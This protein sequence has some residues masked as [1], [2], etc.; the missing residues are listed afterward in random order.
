MPDLA[1][2][3]A[4]APCF[5]ALDE[6]AIADTARQCTVE[7]HD[8]GSI[9]LSQDEACAGLGVVLNGRVRLLRSSP[10]GRE[11]VLRI[12]G[13]GRTFNEAAAI[14]GGGNPATVAA[15]L[16]SRVATLGRAW[17][18]RLLDNHPGF[19]RTMLEL[20]AARERSALQVA[21]DAALRSVP[22]RVA[23]LL[24]R[25]ATADQHLID[26]APDACERI[27][28]QDIAELTGSVRE[29]VQRALKQLEQAG[30]IRLG[31]ADVEVLDVDALRAQASD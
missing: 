5:A 17:L 28:Q 10:D 15:I 2:A 24:L 26:G 6:A 7:E 3:L 14:D 30:A 23:R 22:S 19:C 18:M 12:A 16:P 11:Q 4:A 9:I 27:T 25:C 20:A 8:S 13:P 1:A 29:V 31:R 21:E